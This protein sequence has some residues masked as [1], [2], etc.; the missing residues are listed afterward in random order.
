MYPRIHL[1]GLP[2]LEERMDYYSTILGEFSD[3]DPEF[4]RGNFQ[5]E[6]DYWNN[7]RDLLKESPVNRASKALP[8][9][10]DRSL[11]YL[12]V[13]SQ[14]LDSYYL[15]KD[16]VLAG[17]PQR[18]VYM[19]GRDI[20]DNQ[21]KKPLLFL[22]LAKDIE[23]KRLKESSIETR[24]NIHDSRSVIENKLGKMSVSQRKKVQKYS[25]DPYFEDPGTD[26]IEDM[27][28]KLSDR[29]REIEK[30]LE[31]KNQLEWLDREEFS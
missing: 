22:E 24:I 9:G 13:L 21:N 6:K 8:E 10:S 17:I 4:N 18:M 12:L 3:I 25:I 11:D 26:S 14:V 23:G 15:D 16:F 19:L 20:L 31:E 2:D 30:R 27:A 5:D 1:K 28:G 29:F 7:L